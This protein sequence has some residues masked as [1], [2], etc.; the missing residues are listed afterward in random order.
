M[1]ATE[2][3]RRLAHV[4]ALAAAD[5]KAHDIVVLDVSTQLVITDVFV[6]ASAPNERQ[7]Q[8]I[9]DSVEEKM[10]EA[11]SKPVRREGAREGRWVLLDFVDLVVHIQHTEERS[12]YGL[13]RLWK[14]CPRIE[15]ED[16]VAHQP[17]DE[18]VQA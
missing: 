5:K 18:D 3:S 4:A 16:V 17:E 8:A 1:S 12:F 10:R 11:G 6:I 13:E 14:D 15:F 2:E 9:V 7:V